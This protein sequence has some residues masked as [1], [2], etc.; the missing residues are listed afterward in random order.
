MIAGVSKQPAVLAGLERAL[1]EEFGPIFGLV[2][3]I[4]R[5]GNSTL[6][7]SY[8]RANEDLVTKLELLE[9]EGAEISIVDIDKLLDLEPDFH[10]SLD[11]LRALVSELNAN[12]DV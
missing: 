3:T 11:E 4:I 5:F 1:N 9:T 2:E 12:S 10:L 6:V 8:S 7:M